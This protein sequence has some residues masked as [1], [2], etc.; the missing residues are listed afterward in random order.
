MNSKEIIESVKHFFN[1]FS[2]KL[3]TSSILLKPYRF[4]RVDGCAL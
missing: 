4:C 2:Q 1:L 3:F